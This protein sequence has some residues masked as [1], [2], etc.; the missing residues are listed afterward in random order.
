MAKTEF[1]DNK[2]SSTK[3]SI[4]SF[5]PLTLMQQLKNIINVF[6]L[7]NGTLQTIPQ[8]STNNPLVSFIP[9]VWV[10]LLGI[11]F[12][13]VADLKRYRTDKK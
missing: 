10:M 8:F 4:L 7:V 1:P 12:E 2:I 6:Y 13:L 5:L 11:I 3:Y 9:T